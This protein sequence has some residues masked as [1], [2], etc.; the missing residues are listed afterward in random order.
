ML[1]SVYWPV[2]T[3]KC[4]PSDSSSSPCAPL[5]IRP[6]IALPCQSGVALRLQSSRVEYGLRAPPP[7]AL[8]S[9]CSDC[10][11]AN[12]CT[13]PGWTVKSFGQMVRATNVTSPPAAFATSSPRR[14]SGRRA[15]NSAV[16]AS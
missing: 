13:G 1:P 11:P 6:T 4:P 8:T 16:V 7:S 3:P 10:V 15:K 9:D 12:G 14:R 2:T 5:S